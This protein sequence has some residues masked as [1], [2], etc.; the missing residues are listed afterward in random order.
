MSH[1]ITKSS[2][3]ISVSKAQFFPFS[4]FFFF[5]R[6]FSISPS[7]TLQLI[8]WVFFKMHKTQT[9][10]TLVLRIKTRMTLIRGQICIA[11][12]SITKNK[13]G[14]PLV[15]QRK[16]YPLQ[17]YLEEKEKVFITI[18][19]SSTLNLLEMWINYSFLH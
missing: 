15:L 10:I 16:E 18:T 3:L 9:E 17:N 1:P 13:Q 5:H 19:E 8:Q 2:T 7:T 11:I 12:S 4:M 6:A 14:I